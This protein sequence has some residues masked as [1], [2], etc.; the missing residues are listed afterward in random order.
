MASMHASSERRFVRFLGPFLEA[1]GRE[2]R[3]RHGEVYVRGL[4]LGASRRTAAGI[5][6]AS[7]DD[8]QAIQQFLNQSRWRPEALLDGIAQ[9]AQRLAPGRRDFVID[10]TG[11]DKQGPHAGGVAR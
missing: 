7:G 10:D 9:E 1:F 6:R 2:E 3:R 4:M 8:E 5:A 11:F